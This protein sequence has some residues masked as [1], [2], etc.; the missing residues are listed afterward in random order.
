MLFYQELTLIAN[1]EIDKYFLWPKLYTQAHLALVE[2]HKQTGKQDIG[3]SFPEYKYQYKQED[4]A[5]KE[6]LA[7]GLGSKLRLFAPSAEDLQSLNIHHKLLRLEDY[8]HITSIK[9]VPGKKVSGY[10]SYSRHRVNSSVESLA[11]RYHKRSLAGKHPS[12]TDLTYEQALA[13]YKGREERCNLPYIQLNSLSNDN[14]FRLFIREHT[15][16]ELVQNG[17]SSYGLGFIPQ[18]HSDE[19]DESM[20]I[21]KISTLPK[22]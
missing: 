3:S 7:T 15:A 1:P 16:S 20:R 6:I 19:E 9:E 12:E 8:V 17:F 11:R 10:V 2:Y 14:K 21:S 13:L 18:K 5:G 4:S 22:F